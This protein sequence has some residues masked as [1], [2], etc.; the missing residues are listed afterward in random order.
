MFRCSVQAFDVN[1]SYFREM[2]DSSVI[3]ECER[4][5]RLHRDTTGPLTEIRGVFDRVYSLAG[6]PNKRYR[7][8]VDDSRKI[9]GYL[10]YVVLGTNAV[11]S[12][13]PNQSFANT[14]GHKYVKILGGLMLS[15]AESAASR[16]S[17]S[18]SN[19]RLPSA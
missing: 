2:R 4:Y 14:Q 10:A 7:M 15:S 6:E 18:V 17:S 13:F 11:E 1:P 19:K 3:Y 5:V 8:Q 9:E 12:V 16:S